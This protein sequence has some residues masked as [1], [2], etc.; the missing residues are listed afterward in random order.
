MRLLVEGYCLL[1][2]IVHKGGTMSTRMFYSLASV[3]LVL[4]IGTACSGTPNPGIDLLSG[5][6]SIPQQGVGP[7]TP[8]APGAGNE[9]IDSN[10]T[11][12][13]AL[14]GENS[15]GS[16]ESSQSGGD[17]VVIPVDWITYTDQH[18][19][20]S[21]SYPS[22]YTIL[23][24]PQTLSSISPDLALRIRLMDATLAKGPSASLEIPDFS[25]ELYTNQS[26]TPL[27]NW[28]GSH[29]PSGTQ[30]AIVVDGVQCTQVSL[31]TLQ[32]PNQFVF[33]SRSNYV[34]KFT[35]AGQYS[36][37]MMGSFKFGK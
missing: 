6:G 9:I 11:V 8:Q 20:F 36:L 16:A 4:A 17:N 14:P 33:C 32:A 35:L 28:I 12:Y 21:I 2:L 15:A 24:E 19:G 29:V 22:T 30:V 25:V 27:S 5:S 13:P 31:M 3:L 7:G 10:G 1:F 18:F 26:V 23:G 37:Q 34:Y